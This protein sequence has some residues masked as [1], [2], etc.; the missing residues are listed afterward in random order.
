M[1]LTTAT[2]MYARV[3]T[4]PA[5]EEKE[6]RYIEEKKSSTTV[7]KSY[8]NAS[9]TESPTWTKET[10]GQRMS[11]GMQDAV[12]AVT[13]MV[14]PRTVRGKTANCHRAAFASFLH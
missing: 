10:A 2:R 4:I 7:D 12:T 6:R 5:G 13:S 11:I 14:W 9:E 8:I 1:N 3:K